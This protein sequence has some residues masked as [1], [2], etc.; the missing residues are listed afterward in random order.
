MSILLRSH[1]KKNTLSRSCQFLPLSD[2]TTRLRLSLTSVVDNCFNNLQQHVNSSTL[3]GHEDLTALN[4]IVLTTIS[5]LMFHQ[6]L[7]ALVPTTL[8]QLLFFVNIEQ[9]LIEQYSSTLSIQQ[10]LLNLDNNIA[11]A[12][13]CACS[14][15]ISACTSMKSVH[16]K[17]G[18]SP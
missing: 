2:R 6:V 16:V 1:G 3:L 5:K 17:S 12:H 10:V 14:V 15:R 8:Q 18:L 11:H 7:S 4:N 13:L 9:L